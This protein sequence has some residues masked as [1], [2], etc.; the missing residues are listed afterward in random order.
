MSK[1]VEATK[2]QVLIKINLLIALF[3]NLHEYNI[4]IKNHISTHLIPTFLET[5]IKFVSKIVDV[6]TSYE[7]LKFSLNLS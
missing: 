7:I 5:P 3:D 1:I 4:I 6:E 2:S